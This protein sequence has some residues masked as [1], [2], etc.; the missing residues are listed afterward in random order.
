MNA[1]IDDAY[2]SR[3]TAPS[4]PTLQRQLSIIERMSN[5]EIRGSDWMLVERAKKAGL[6][7]A[8]LI[9]GIAAATTAPVFADAGEVP[10]RYEIDA[11]HVGG[12]RSEQGEDDAV[13]RIG[14]IPRSLGGPLVQ[15]SYSRVFDI[16]PRRA[17]RWSYSHL[18]ARPDGFVSSVESIAAI[19]HSVRL[20]CI[21]DGVSHPAESRAREHVKRF[22]FDTLFDAATNARSSAHAGEMIKLCGR[23]DNVGGPQRLRLV[24]WGL[25]SSSVEVRESTVQ[26]VENWGAQELTP[27]LR[28]HDEP[29]DW[30]RDYL[31]DVVRDLEG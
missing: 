14:E 9:Q 7:F 23:L 8:V 28:N 19:E 1:L 12:S 16:V 5:T 13:V 11:Q 30:L 25:G 18:V 29:V 26:A 15:T 3:T 31:R 4:I 10:L 22:G 6:K 24:V 2:D 21:E 20:E 27:L 17:L